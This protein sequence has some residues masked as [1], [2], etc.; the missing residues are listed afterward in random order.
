MELMFPFIR[1]LRID[2]FVTDADRVAAVV[3]IVRRRVLE[4][5]VPAIRS[6]MSDWEW[7]PG[8]TVIGY[9]LVGQ[10][11]DDRIFSLLEENLEY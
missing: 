3:D 7:T 2:F 5:H 6:F 11:A 8:R 9:S 4:E 10:F 1:V